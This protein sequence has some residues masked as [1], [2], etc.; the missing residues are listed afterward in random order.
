MLEITIYS[1]TFKGRIVFKDGV[2][3]HSHFFSHIQ[4]RVDT[5]ACIFLLRNSKYQASNQQVK[6]DQDFPLKFLVPNP[7][8]E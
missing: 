6:Y 8:Y 1:K 7:N 5:L 2:D 3:F 4:T